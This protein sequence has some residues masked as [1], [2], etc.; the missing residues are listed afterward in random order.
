MVQFILIVLLAMLL[1]VYCSISTMFC[2]LWIIC[3]RL[4]TPYTNIGGGL[5]MLFL[6]ST[7]FV[8]RFSSRVRGAYLFRR[9][10]FSHCCDRVLYVFFL[11]TL[12]TTYHRFS[13][14]T[15]SHSSSLLIAFLWVAH[16]VYFGNSLAVAS[17]M[18]TAGIA[19]EHF[20][21]TYTRGTALDLVELVHHM[22]PFDWGL[23]PV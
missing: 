23:Q 20:A 8:L 6:A 22:L 2:S 14:L 4:S 3:G 13:L 16:V 18:C 9:L 21:F 1:V 5:G 12:L 17:E 15:S 11:L 7:L 10:T 19:D